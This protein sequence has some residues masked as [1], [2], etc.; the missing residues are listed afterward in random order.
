MSLEDILSKPGSGFE[1]V[2]GYADVYPFVRVGGLQQPAIWPDTVYAAPGEPI[3][4]GISR[5]P[6]APAQMIVYA[7]LG[8]PGPVSAIVTAVP[9]GSDTVTVTEGAK[10]YSVNFASD[11][12]LA[13]GDRVRL[14]WQG[15][16]GTAICKVGVTPAPQPAPTTTAP[17]PAASQSGVLTVQATDSGT[18]S[19][20][21][22][23]NARYGQNV[24]QGNAS[25]WGGPSSN[26][27]AWFYGAGAG[28]LLGATITGVTF[29]VPARTSAGA[30]S[31]S[32]ALHFFLHNS[33]DK[34]GGDVNRT[35]GPLDYVIPAGYRGGDRISLPASWGDQLV[36]GGGIGVAGDPYA[37]LNGRG[38][39]P[40]SGQLQLTWQ[41]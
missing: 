31:S 37:G 38:T 12:T 17:P 19:N 14:L 39:D 23:W 28:Q 32:V 20:G 8:K 21:Y 22:G 34:P 10:D 40:E 15:P 25:V 16:V 9:A 27:G 29:R 30:T 4:V 7:R 5:K 1:V 41:R 2:P 35:A 26:Q 6:D 3:L 13:P 18:Y 24:Y 33:P 36:A 11:L